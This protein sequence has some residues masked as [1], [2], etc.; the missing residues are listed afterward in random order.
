MEAHDSHYGDVFQAECN[1]A[2]LIEELLLF[3]EANPVKNA[4]PTY[5]EGVEGLYEKLV[6]WKQSLP[7]CLLPS[8]TEIPSVLILQ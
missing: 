8:S 3:R 7:D 5:M 4:S 2:I 1:L 6:I